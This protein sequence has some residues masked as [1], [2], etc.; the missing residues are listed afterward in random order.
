MESAF[1]WSS[2]RFNTLQYGRIGGLIYKE[3][4]CILISSE[5]EEGRISC[6]LLI[7]VPK[8]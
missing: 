5:T 6:K 7:K 2:G 1:N 4:S 8:I 3:L